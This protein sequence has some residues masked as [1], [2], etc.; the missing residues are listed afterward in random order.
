VVFAGLFTLGYMI[1]V[2]AGGLDLSGGYAVAQALYVPVGLVA[3]VLASVVAWS[4]GSEALE[5]VAW[6]LLASS[7]AAFWIADVV[8]VVE[9]VAGGSV[10][11]PAWSD[12][13][14]LAYYPLLLIAT[15]MLCRR[16]EASAERLRIALDMGII[17]LGGS[18]LVW[19]FVMRP[20]LDGLE[21]GLGAAITVAYSIG[22]LFLVVGIAT[23]AVRPNRLRS[24]TSLML[25]L[26]A[27]ITG[28]VADLAYGYT[29][30]LDA[31]D[32]GDTIDAVYLVAWFL[33]A[34]AAAAEYSRGV[35]QT[36]ARASSTEGPKLGDRAT[37]LSYAAVVI[38]IAAL[39]WVLREH[40]GAGE[41]VAAS[42]A[43]LVTLL[44]MARQVV[45]SRDNARLRA[46][47]AVK[48]SEERFQEALKRTQFLVD[49]AGESILWF[50]PEGR[51]VDAN[52]TACRMLGYSR[53]ELLGLSVSQIDPEFER[54]PSLWAVHWDL[55][56][57]QRSRVFEAAHRTKS[58]DV[59]P[60]EVTVN[61][62]EY[63]GE[64]FSCSFARDISERKR[65]EES[66][67][68]AEA[69]LRQSQ[70]MDAVGQLAGG[71]AH[72]FNNLLTA[73]LGYCELI[74]VEDG[75][76]AESLRADVAEIRG[77]A[78][79]AAALTR[80]I[81]TFSRRQPLEPKITSLNDV[82]ASAGRLLRRTLGEHID[83]VTRLD[84][85]TGAV[86]V[87]PTQ[88]EQVVMN[89]AVNARDAMPEGGTLTI[90]TGKVEIDEGYCLSHPGMQP[91][92]YVVLAVS[93]SGVGMDEDTKN[94][95]FEPFFTTKEKGKGTGLGLATVY[96]IVKQSGGDIFIYS[97]PGNGTTV[98]VLLPE[99]RGGSGEARTAQG[100]KETTASAE[101]RGP[102]ARN[103]SGE[104][105]ILLVE[106]EDGLRSL[107]RR[108]LESRGYMVR[109]GATGEEA[110]AIL[111]QHG[112]GI[113]LLLTDMI[114]PGSV[115]GGE[116][117]Q[118]ARGIL[119]ELPVLFMSGYTREAAVRAGKV[120]S[121][122]DYLEKPFTPEALVQ[123]VRRAL[124]RDGGDSVSA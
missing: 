81:L 71:I 82:V 23:L 68:E 29:T 104:K 119:P 46:E 69:R 72:D 98:K 56:L 111:H 41:G 116:L 106:D 86:E 107:V 3:V 88:F 40:F 53:E 12:I 51:V 97:E 94:R 25:L 99:A 2:T 124:A 8:W 44:V 66:L 20:A 80:Q 101:E 95:A 42:V 108:I 55:L 109:E 36:G 31:Y 73:I 7:L 102:L 48:A 85:A 28:F 120:G 11:S 83:L 89:L 105:T 1:W 96:G 35:K 24:H 74:L 100:A 117:A 43:V 18:C 39:V 121:E 13:G 60:V 32:Y 26:A 16:A 22:D 5:R 34:A 15:L 76:S 92:R 67:H 64:R 10:Q 113:G 21:G 90:E 77:A 123:R 17:F 45:V 57:K 52:V 114:L 6:T 112:P 58:G 9:E 14:Y 110:L 38:A 84:S 87:D 33:F 50:D 47:K 93:D 19:Y 62:L 75:R 122:V 37:I 30:L 4:R 91:G 27:V 118:R 78:E 49:H 65:A 79:R 115:Q 103:T 61:Y 59:V 54:D 70:K 63:G